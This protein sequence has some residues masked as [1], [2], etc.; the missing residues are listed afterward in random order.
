MDPDGGD[1]GRGGDVVVSVDPGLRDLSAFRRIRQ[2]KAER[3][4]SGRGT[5]KHGAD[6]DDAEL[7]V[8]VGTQLFADDGKLVA[9]LR[10]ENG[11]C[12][13]RRRWAGWPRKRALRDA[14]Q[15]DA[16]LCGDRPSRR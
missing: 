4:G 1:G 6:G 15:T 9:D 2:V 14:D 11:A 12:R 8:P 10:T 13:R 16:A 7:R 3:G 5:K